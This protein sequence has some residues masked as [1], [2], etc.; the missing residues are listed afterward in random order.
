MTAQG[1]RK[2][3]PSVR[4]AERSPRPSV[5]A[6]EPDLEYR[7]ALVSIRGARGALLGGVLLPCEDLAAFARDVLVML[8]LRRSREQF[9]GAGRTAAEK[10]ALAE[11]E[12]AVTAAHGGME[13]PLLAAARLIL[14]GDALARLVRDSA[15][16]RNG[17]AR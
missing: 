5:L 2:G 3:F 4:Y 7:S 16:E 14:A 15:A 12:S 17:N 9:P 10:G 11:W 13:R 8:G 6:V 1:T